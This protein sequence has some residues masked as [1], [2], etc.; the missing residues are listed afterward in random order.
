MNNYPVKATKDIGELAVDQVVLGI[1]RTDGKKGKSGLCIVAPVVSSAVLNLVHNNETGKAWI[2]NCIDDLRSR[3]ASAANKAGK[4]ITSEML[5][6]DALLVAMGEENASNRLSKESIAVW[7][8]EVMGELIT[9]RIKAKMGDVTIA[10]DKL[11]KLVEGYKNQFL[12]LAGRGNLPEAI[13]VQLATA[14]ELLPEDHDNAVT[15]KIA[16][17]LAA[18]AV[19]AEE[20]MAL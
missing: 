8:D 7:F 19:P 15:T 11:V 2:V 14:L 13:R 4:S 9:K 20:L 18:M 16:E 10:D 17:K 3:I 12:N 6:I 5:G 1:A